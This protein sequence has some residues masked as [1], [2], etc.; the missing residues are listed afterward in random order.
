MVV[1]RRSRLEVI[2]DI[3]FLIQSK[4]GKVKPTHILYGANLSHG[5]LKEN[6][7]FLISKDFI[8][9]VGGDKRIFYEITKEGLSQINEFRRIQKFKNAFGI[10]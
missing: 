8:R 1:K 7:D 10:D 9:R 3:M 4:G 5:V 6:L 2:M